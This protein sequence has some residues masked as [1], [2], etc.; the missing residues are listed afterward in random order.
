M[1][2]LS[3]NKHQLNSF[4][5]SWSK[6]ENHFNEDFFFFFL[7]KHSSNLHPV[8]SLIC[9]CPAKGRVEGLGDV[10]AMACGQ[11]HC[12]ALC[13]SGLVFSWGA[14]DDGQLG[15]CPMP[16]G[17]TYRPRQAFGVWSRPIYTHTHT[18]THTV[19]KIFLNDYCLHVTMQ[20]GAHTVAHRNNSGCLWKLPF[21]GTDQR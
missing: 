9:L 5:L 6:R 14:A 15:V 21:P 17:I 2:S 16:Q 7:S 11:D 1:L 12:L 8:D 18:H 19:F 4:I 10:V 20:P 13:A 3:N